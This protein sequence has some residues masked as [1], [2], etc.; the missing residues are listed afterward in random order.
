MRTTH[1]YRPRK[2]RTRKVVSRNVKQYVNKAIAKQ[3]ETKFVNN[4]LPTAFSSIG[5]TWVEQDM[6]AIAQGAGIAQRN[7]HEV[8]ITGFNLRGTLV[9]GQSNLA[10][11][12]NRNTVRII[13]A[14]W[15]ASSAGPLAA[16]GATIDSYISK[17]T[18][19][20]RGLIKKHID[21]IIELPTAGRDSTG[22]L[23]AIK[24][25]KFFKKLRT[26]IRYYGS[27]STNDNKKLILSM[28]SDSAAVSNP[29]FTQG[30][31]SVFFEDA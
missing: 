19:V 17:N 3:V 11:D 27:A 30:Y 16:N 14:T 6:T 28:I 9:G 5:N 1:G 21:K 7:G 13:L 31:Y 18:T 15:D 4:T 22:Y 26:F 10:T 25:V 2:Y 12:D 29:G 8:K 23:P 24:L 20:S